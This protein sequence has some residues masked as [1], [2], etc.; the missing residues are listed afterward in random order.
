ML[1]LSSADFFQNEPFQ[2]ILLGTLFKCQTVWIQ[3]RTDT[4]SVL[5]WVQ[6]VC[7]GYQQTSKVAASKAIVKAQLH[8]LFS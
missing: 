6:T 5:I 1:L 2:K 7:K 8:S 3:I 4:L